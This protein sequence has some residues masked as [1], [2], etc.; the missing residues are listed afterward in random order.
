MFPINI[1]LSV[2]FRIAPIIVTIIM[3]PYNVNKISKYYMYKIPSLKISRYFHCKQGYYFSTIMKSFHRSL[4]SLNGRRLDKQ[5]LFNCT[6]F[7][8]FS[9]FTFV[10]FTSVHIRDKSRR[11]E[12]YRVVYFFQRS[13]REH[14]VSMCIGDIDLS[15]TRRPNSNKRRTKKRISV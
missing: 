11:F 2:H 6:M 10:L 5:R 8:F 3:S 1:L 9:S 14:H 12:F 4:T 7:Y 15:F 13:L